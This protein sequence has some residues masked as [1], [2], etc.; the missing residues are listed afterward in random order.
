MTKW[1]ILI[2]TLARRGDALGQVLADLGPQLA[3]T[4]D[5]I[6]VVALRNHAERPLGDVRQ[7]L[8]DDA[9]GEY[10]S[11]VDDDDRLPDYYVSR[12]LPLLDGVDYIGW[13]M[14]C[15]EHGRP[16]NPTFHSLQYSRWFETPDAY[17]RD[18]SHLNPVRRELAADFRCE[19]PPEDVDWVIRMRGRLTTEHF[20]DDVMYHYYQSAADSSWRAGREP[21]W[22]GD[23][24]LLTTPLVH[25]FDHIPGFRW[26]PGS[27]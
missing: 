26:H 14:Q 4:G 10:I 11:F 6:E 18:I 7:S 25:R 19:R 13:R 1:S 17:Y 15:Y 8:V 20:I 21:V 2:A 9:R 23:T 24:D 12:V 5:Q 3:A 22:G 16:L 27:T